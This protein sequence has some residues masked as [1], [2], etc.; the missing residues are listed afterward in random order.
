MDDL[1]WV[2]KCIQDNAATSVGPEIVAMYC[3]CMNHK[4]GSSESESISDWEKS[5]TDEKKQ[6]E[7]ESGWK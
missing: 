3:A 7:S 4:M 1:K 6:C 2:S 5:H